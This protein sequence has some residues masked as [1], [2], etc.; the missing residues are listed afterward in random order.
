MRMA[1]LILTIACLFSLVSCT[2][3]KGDPNTALSPMAP[4]NDY[5][6]G[7]SY[8]DPVA[9]LRGIYIATVYNLDFPSKPGLPAE[10]LSAELDKIVEN[11]EALGCNA[12]Y[13]Q[14]RGASDAMYDSEIFPVSEY[15]T[16]KKN[17]ELPDGFDPF[18][19]LI[20]AA[21]A[22][23]IAVHAWVNPL[24]VT[25]GGTPQKPKTD[26]DLLPKDSP[27][28]SVPELTVAYAGEL[29]YDAGV[30]AV[31]ELVAR[32]VSEIVT[33]YD[34]DGVLFDDYFYPYPEDGYEF[35]DADS[36]E[37][38]GSGDIGNWRRENINKMVK[39]CYEAVKAADPDCRFGIAP[40]GIW[41]NDDGENGGSDTRG[42]ESYWSIYCDTLAWV[43]GGYIDYVAPQIYW[44][45]SHKSAPY[46]VLADWWCAQL[47]GTGV[48]LYVS[49]AAYKYGTD[50]WKF[51]G[52]VGEMREQLTY[53]RRL[54]TYRGSILYGYSELC[55]DTGGVA[56]EVAECFSDD[57][58]YMTPIP[59][60]I[61]VSITQP[62]NGSFVS[63]GTVTLHGK[64]APEE[65]VFCNGEK[66]SR[67]RG[68]EFYLTVTLREGENIFEFY[69]GGIRAEY[70]VFYDVNN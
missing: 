28:R 52:A 22:H 14:V 20:D 5:P 53:A 59:T 41:Q 3:D 61:G 66:V 62:D 2:R 4:D 65:P 58:Y 47:D 16:G 44:N 37:K 49:H 26:P 64:S 19:Y 31:R 56:G 34:V 43:K 60:G 36:F 54:I 1:A 55:A 63:A 12:I 32:G 27:A 13:F 30:P 11:T 50:D 23:G 51:A 18:R 33:N 67:R 39:S 40:F 57:I 9:E 15:L 29:Y 48:E 69:S 6:A 10:V 17:G 70:K 68:G 38:Y 35:D 21:H 7:G 24:R 25:R 45:F 46:G 8:G 42:L